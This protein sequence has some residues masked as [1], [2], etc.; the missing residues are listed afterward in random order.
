MDASIRNTR[1]LYA[2]WFLRDFQLWIPVWIIFL[3]LEQ[4][5][6]LTEITFAEGLYLIGVVLLEVPTGAVAD[7]WGRSRSLGLGAFTLAAAV[8]VFAFATNYAI[9][10]VSFFM[11]SVASTLM[12]GADRALLFET[13]KAA[14]QEE[15]YERIAGRGLAFTWIGIG[16]ATLLGG[17]VA[18]LL[19]TEA[20]IYIGSATC[21][22]T[23]LVAFAMKEAPHTATGDVQ[24]QNYL[25]SIGHAF[26]ETW[27]D[28][29][30]R[31]IVLLSGAVL[32]GM[33]SVHYLIQPYLLDRG[34]E[35]GTL[36]SFLQVPLFLAG[37][38]GALLVGR[39]TSTSASAR[40]L[41]VLP[42]VGGIGCLALAVTPGLGAYA[43]YPLIMAVASAVDPLT[44]GIIN[45][46]ASSE[47][48]AT[49]LS[50][51][52]MMRSLVMAIAAPGVGYL[53]DTYG[54]GTAFTGSAAIVLL[55]ILLFGAPVFARRKLV[56]Q[57]EPVAAG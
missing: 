9:L 20:T 8:L 2:F 44:S 7:K 26:R 43:A 11:W 34:I 46:A 32:A 5:F 18:E 50:I 10:L 52:G 38:A 56:A 27:S 51:S 31:P 57:G 19:S 21:V 23:G 15:K 48:R 24:T 39:I 42:L 1:L 54:L 13:L 55:A 33:E 36:F 49:I 28:T 12:S 45:R 4:G 22:V 6:T 40:A 35:V 47:R 29:T 41:I 53:T 16:I 25:V 37:L 3:V 30:I 14:G 17:P